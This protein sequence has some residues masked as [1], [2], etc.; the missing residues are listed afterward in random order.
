MVKNSH[1][2]NFISTDKPMFGK[3]KREIKVKQ[4]LV[5]ILLLMT[6]SCTGRQTSSITEYQLDN[7]LSVILRPIQGTKLIALVV[8]YSIGEDH[9]PEGK[10]G[11]GHLIEHLYV[12]AA[13]GSTKARNIG[14]YIARYPDGWNAQTGRNYTVIATVFP[15]ERLESEIQDAAARMRELSITENDLKQEIP[16]IEQEL[17]NMYSAIP[18][19]AAQNLASEMVVA[20]RPGARKGGVIEQ[21]KSIDLEN[22]RKRIQTLYKPQNAT[23][24]IAGGIEPEE[25]RKA[26]D[27]EFATIDSGYRMGSPPSFPRPSLDKTEKK[28]IGRR[29]PQAQSHV[30]IAFSTPKPSEKL[31]PAFMIVAARLQLNSSQLNSPQG[32]F[33]LTFAP[34]DRPEVLIVNLPVGENE[35]GQSV[36]NRLKSFV[37][38]TVSKNLDKRDIEAT[39]QVFGFT[40]GF[41]EYPDKVLANNVYGVA[42]SLGR[43]AQL[44][45]DSK[46]LLEDI[47]RVTQE[48]LKKATEVYFDFLN[49]GTV[50]AEV[51]DN[52]PN[53]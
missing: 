4:I 40:L 39:K 34:L 38:G 16:R 27:R 15:K 49:C 48:D 32:V 46:R 25:V 11:M 26:I 13:V 29:F 41:Q 33:P 20:H 8:L 43:R 44:G 24:I 12:T 21:I 5:L 3:H 7:G 51:T 18:A 30:A 10:S 45:I 37:T 17:S 52:L 47:S 28:R 14:E 6:I 53:K 36:L 35:E 9:D 22:L 42:F 2:C 50:I 31:F 23:I 1:K 19:L